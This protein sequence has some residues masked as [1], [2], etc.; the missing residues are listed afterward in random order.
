MVGEDGTIDLR[1]PLVIERGADFL[2]GE[3]R[4]RMFSR[5]WDELF[6]DVRDWDGQ[7]FHYYSA[8]THGLSVERLRWSVV[9][10]HAIV[11]S[12]PPGWSGNP[13]STPATLVLAGPR[14]LDY[15]KPE[16]PPPEPYA[17]CGPPG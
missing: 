17:P 4:Y 15:R 16:P 6:T 5:D 13:E 12:C 14:E 8:E 7:V 1:Y 11:R 9:Y 10:Y 3:V 2:Y